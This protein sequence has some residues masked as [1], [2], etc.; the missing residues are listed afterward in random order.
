MEHAPPPRG[1]TAS[2]EQ[3]VG[4]LRRIEGQVRGVQRM[5]DDD[6]YCID[7]IT[8]ISAFRALEKVALGLLDDHPATASSARVRGC[9]RS[10][11]RNWSRR[12][13][14]CSAAVG[15][16]S[17]AG[18]RGKSPA[19]LRP[20]TRS[21]SGWT[22]SA[23]KAVGLEQR[24]ELAGGAIPA[25]IARGGPRSLAHSRV[26]LRRLEHG[27]Q[28]VR[29][30]LA[31]PLGRHEETRVLGHRVDDASH[32]RPDYRDTQSQAFQRGDT[33]SFGV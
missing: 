11:P 5:V 22:R 26:A 20:Q 25:L 2:K 19:R 7:V 24:E 32:G 31:R 4:R 16:R 12:L 9:A 6:R 14:G 17:I 28:R 13:G 29:E 3:L 15:G 8:Q 33:E 23:S 1:Y 21:T 18:S 30:V 10:A 27:G